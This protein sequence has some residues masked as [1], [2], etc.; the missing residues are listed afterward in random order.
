MIIN[1]T[2][3]D[4]PLIHERFAYKYLRKDVCP[5]GDVVLFRAPMFVKEG[6]IDLEDTLSN[7]YI[8]SADAV[9]ICWEI[10]N[11]C[12]LGAVSF[13]RLF[14][15]AIASI[16]SNLIGKPIQMD[17]DDL[18]V[19]DDFIG[20]DKEKHSIG[21]VSVSIT[22]SKENVAIGHTGINIDAGDQAPGFA[23]SSKLSEYHV[24]QFMKEVQEYFYAETRDQFIASAKVIV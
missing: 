20:S 12:P 24:T 4:G 21:K 18:M 11:M 7:D 9:N 17:G 6:L 13:Q 10:P 23:Y 16:L 8:A 3:Y 19:V 2:I 14:N 5:T 22:Y 1:E 15:T